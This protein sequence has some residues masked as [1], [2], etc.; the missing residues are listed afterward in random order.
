VTVNLSTIGNVIFDATGIGNINV[1]NKAQFMQALRFG[2][3]QGSVLIQFATPVIAAGFYVIDQTFPGDLLISASLN[4]EAI[5]PF[6]IPHTAPSSGASLDEGVFYV[7][8]VDLGG[9]DFLEF[10]KGFI[11]IVFI[12][13]FNAFKASELLM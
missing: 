9:F 5:T 8:V 4:G 1:A 2:T 10:N 11:D 13:N 6:V 3:L 7:G 12:D